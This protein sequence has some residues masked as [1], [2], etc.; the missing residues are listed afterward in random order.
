MTKEI[1]VNELEQVAGGTVGEL[2]DLMSANTS[3]NILAE[4]GAHVPG[5]NNGAATTMR[6]RLSSLGIDAD[7]SLGFAGTGFGSKANKYTNKAT[8]ERMSHQE[9][10][11]VLKAN[12]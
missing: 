7:I 1:K 6:N 2:E 12:S 10:L 5:F 9:V 11:E 4:G 8:G 3:G